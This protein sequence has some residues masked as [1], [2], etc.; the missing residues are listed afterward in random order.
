MGPYIHLMCTFFNEFL[1]GHLTTV[2]RLYAAGRPEIRGL[3]H[4]LL[5]QSMGGAVAIKA[6]L[7]E[8]EEWDGL[9]LVA[10][11]CKVAILPLGVLLKLL[12]ST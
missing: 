12:S 8:P 3:P 6:L 11:V 7:K 5:G 4:F 1:I 2:A 10:P 9:V